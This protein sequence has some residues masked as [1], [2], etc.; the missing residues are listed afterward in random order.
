MTWYCCFLSRLPFVRCAQ[1][2]LKKEHDRYLGKHAEISN[3]MND[4]LSTCLL[5]KPKDVYGF[6]ADYFNAFLP[7]QH[8][9][10][11]CISGNI[12]NNNMYKLLVYI[13]PV[14]VL[15]TSMNFKQYL[16]YYFKHLLTINK[17][18]IKIENLPIYIYTHPYVPT[19]LYSNE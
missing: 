17:K 13:T 15:S 19:A 18:T 11:M 9:A 10:P 12:L 14:F 1:D 6:A 7:N 8:Y 5:E 16:L 2:K 3:L 4:F